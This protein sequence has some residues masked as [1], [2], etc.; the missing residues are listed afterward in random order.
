MDL[1]HLSV[2]TI[3]EIRRGIDLLDEADPKRGPLLTGSTGT[4]G[5]GSQGD[6]WP[7]PCITG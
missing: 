1:L 3:G 4:C 7:S 6:G 5:C 2:I